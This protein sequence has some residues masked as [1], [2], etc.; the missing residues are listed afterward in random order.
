MF[1][2]KKKAPLDVNQIAGAAMNAFMAPDGRP[3]NGQHQNHRERG[4]LG[5]VGAVAVG[6]ALALTARAAYTR[7]RRDLDLEQVADAVEDRLKG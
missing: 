6:A 5:S 2:K 7:A 1:G 4:G 3:E